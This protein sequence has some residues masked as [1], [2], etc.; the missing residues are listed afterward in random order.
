MRSGT[1]FLKPFAILSIRPGSE[2]FNLVLHLGLL[3]RSEW[4]K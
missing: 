2:A 4:S 3:P 1:C